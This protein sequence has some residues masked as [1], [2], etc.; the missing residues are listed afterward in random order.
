MLIT[1]FAIE[2]ICFFSK[3]TENKCFHPKCHN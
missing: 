2:T 3:S 1:E